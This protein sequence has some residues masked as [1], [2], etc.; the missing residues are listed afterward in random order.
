MTS[1]NELEVFVEANVEDPFF[2]DLVNGSFITTLY[3]P[4][5]EL[6]FLGQQPRAFKPK[7]P[8]TTY[9]SVSQLGGTPLSEFQ[10]KNS[11][12]EFK[13]EINDGKSMANQII[14][15][16]DSNSIAKFTF[17]PDAEAEFLIITATFISNFDSSNEDI[18]AI[19]RAVRYKSPSNSYIQV[20]SSTLNP[21]V[22]YH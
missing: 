21:Q 22:I 1:L 11:F 15:E 5:I 19:E 6:T 12:V 9:L 20:T 13:I 18:I 4:K 3:D 16:I 7:M 10:I 17:I 14:V 2:A 8:Y